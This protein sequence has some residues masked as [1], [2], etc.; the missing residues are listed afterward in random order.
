MSSPEPAESPWSDAPGSSQKAS[1]ADEASPVVSSADWTA[2][3]G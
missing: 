3:A 2:G 1:S